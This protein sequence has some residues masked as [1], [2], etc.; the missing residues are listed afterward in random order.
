MRAELGLTE[1]EDDEPDVMEDL[2]LFHPLPYALTT[3]AAEQKHG[4]LPERGGLNDQS[5]AWGHDRGQLNR[6]YNIT[7]AR[8]LP[9]MEAGYGRRRQQTEDLD[10]GSAMGWEDIANG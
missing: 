2:P 10:T 1:D 8:L 9:E 5:A 6:L 3:W 7:F 4:L